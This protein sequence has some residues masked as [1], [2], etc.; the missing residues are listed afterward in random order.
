MHQT[1]FAAAAL[2]AILSGCAA[3][4]TGSNSSEQTKR[5]ACDAG[6]LSTMWEKTR[7][8]A[9]GLD[10]KPMISKLPPCP[11]AKSNEAIGDERDIANM[12]VS[13]GIVAVPRLTQ[14]ANAVLEKL[15]SASGA[16]QIPGKVYVVANDQL[17]AAATADGN[18]YVSL[19]YFRNLDNEDQLAALLAHELSH[20]LLRHHDSS[21]FGRFTKQAMSYFEDTAMVRNALD[22]AMEGDFGGGKALTP[23]QKATL[24]KMNFLVKLNDRALHPAWGRRQ[25]AEAD[26]LGTDLLMRAGYSFSDGMQAWLAKVA[27]YDDQQ[28]AVRQELASQRQATIDALAAQ[29]KVEASVRK[30]ADGALKDLLEDVGRSHEDGTNRLRELNGYIE[31]AYNDNIDAPDAQVTSHRQVMTMP[32]VKGTLDGY[33]EAFRARSQILALQPAAAVAALRKLTSGGPIASHA[34][35][36]YLLFE[37]QAKA[38]PAEREPALRRSLAASEPI[39]NSVESSAQFY[40]GRNPKELAAIGRKALRD[41]QNAPSAYPR[42][43]SWYSRVGLKDEAASVLEDCRRNEAQMRSACEK[44]LKI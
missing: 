42:L 26:R 30:A 3:T 24:D 4:T 5:P 23:S 38:R 32:D 11:Y 15:K 36:N 44:A 25:E 14:Y 16:S 22:R 34:L 21:W 31:K 43:I 37:A 9:E 7:D 13:H 19:G 17:D 20:V 27:A 33:R 1:A 18:V 12:R 6:A 41:F 40:S 2:A 8:M 39:W 28:R 35:P 10:A 29:G